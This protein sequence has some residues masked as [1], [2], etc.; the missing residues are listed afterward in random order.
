M[1]TGRYDRIECTD[2]FT[3]LQG[4]VASGADL[5]GT[6]IMVCDHTGETLKV[7]GW[8]VADLHVVAR[9]VDQ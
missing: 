7:N 3:D 4:L 8:M 9:G 1:R 5:D 2:G 6:F